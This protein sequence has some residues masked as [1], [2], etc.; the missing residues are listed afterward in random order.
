MFLC[1]SSELFSLAASCGRGR[2]KLKLGGIRD[3]TGTVV[4]G[5]LWLVLDVAGACVPSLQVSTPGRGLV[6][7][8]PQL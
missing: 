4:R 1:I 7:A 3:V 2:R 5:S 6:V 8:S